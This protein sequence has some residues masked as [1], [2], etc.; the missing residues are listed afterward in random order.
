M[1]IWLWVGFI[2][3]VL[4][5]LAVD[6]GVINRK[7]HVIKAREA[8]SWTAVWIAMALLFNLLIYYMYEHHWLG[9][10]QSVGHKMGG[11][12]AA[13]KFFTGYLIE[14]SL[15]LDN[16]F[17]IALI[18]S[19]FKVPLQYQHRV[20]YWGILGA[21]VMRGILILTGAALIDRFSWIIYVFGIFLILTSVKMLVTR[22]DTIDPDKN[23]LIRYL[24]KVFP[25]SSGIHGQSFFT[26][27]NGRKAVTPMFLVLVLIES[28]DVLF[29]VDSIPAIFAITTD[30]FIVFTSNIFA[31]LGLRALYFALA[32]I[33]EK[34]VYLKISLVFLLAYIGV[35][36]TLSPHFH[37]PTFFTLAVIAVILS[38]GIAASVYV[39]RRGS[40]RHEAL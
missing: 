25:I 6:L 32:V 3:L 10:G 8:L 21:I 39:N 22:H 33:I 36:M 20:L 4:F 29:A 9:I 26:R 13:L 23:L 17:V 34:F 38:V 35:K 37:I 1:T 7:A 19:Y 30:S 2:L 27:I 11:G 28:S 16:I 5:F 14:K 31:I 24:K 15:S 40:A 18:F 12:E